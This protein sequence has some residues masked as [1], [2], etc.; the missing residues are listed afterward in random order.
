MR[1]S[2][3]RLVTYQPVRYTKDGRV[4]AQ[5]IAIGPHNRNTFPYIRL[6][7]GFSAILYYA[8]QKYDES[9][10][11]APAMRFINRINVVPYG[12]L[13]TS[14]A[15]TG[16]ARNITAMPDANTVVVDPT[17]LEAIKGVADGAVGTSGA[18]Y[19]AF[20][21]KGMFP[22]AVRSAIWGTTDAKFYDHNGH[23]V[24][25]VVSPDFRDGQWTEREAS[26][27]LSRA[28]RNVL[29]EFAMSEAKTLRIV[30]LASGA[31]SGALYNQIPPLTQEA[32]HAAFDQ[33]HEFDKEAVMQPDRKY[34]LCIF[35]EREWDAYAKVFTMVTPPSKLA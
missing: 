25:H 17:T 20:G 28:Y 5:R 2:L 13:G 1:A 9:K 35:M 30:P 23:R 15:L 33:L 18:I 19:N 29:H 16:S 26:L 3:R 22:E 10:Y 6:G 11:I 21:I 14:F 12:G 31:L 24:I 32:L 7:I 34:E 4:R 8:K 27:E